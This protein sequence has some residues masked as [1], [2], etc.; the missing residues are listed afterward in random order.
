MK[1]LLLTALLL[2]AC[3]TTA[4]VTKK[5]D[6]APVK[7]SNAETR[8]HIK[9]TQTH[10]EASQKN[11]MQGEDSLGNVDQLLEKLENQ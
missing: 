4:V 7:E 10:I 2:S 9:S 8:K 5:P 1:Y 3:T 6:V 11:S